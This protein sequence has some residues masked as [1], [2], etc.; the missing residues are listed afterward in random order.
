MEK[1]QI[2]DVIITKSHASGERSLLVLISMQVRTLLEIQSSWLSI[3]LF[4][5]FVRI[6]NNDEENLDTRGKT[7]PS[8]YDLWHFLF[9]PAKSS[10]I[11]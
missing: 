11:K 1:S 4:S 3:Q 9:L 10:C 8:H 2:C 5:A 7:L 6:S